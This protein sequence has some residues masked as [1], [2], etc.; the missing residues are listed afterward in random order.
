M[1]II[2]FHLHD[3]EKSDII[4]GF[5]TEVDVYGVVNITHGEIEEERIKEVLSNVDVTDTPLYMS[6]KITRYRNNIETYFNVNN[7]LEK[8]TFEIVSDNKIYSQFVHIRVMTQLPF[9]SGISAE[10]L[11][12]S[13]TTLRKQLVNGQVVFNFP[14]TNIYL[15]GNDY[16]NGL[17][18]LSGD[19]TVG[20][21]CKESTDISE[22]CSLNYKKRRGENMEMV[23][24][25]FSL[26]IIIYL[27]LYFR[28][29]YG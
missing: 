19:P 16:E 18:G 25:Y 11:K 8:T 27:L 2:G 21:I 26:F 5:P 3:E 4:H 17:I 15:M 1:L 29:Y 13:F 12:D 7:R 24:S 28:M 14:K 20:E 10:C 23:H 9:I 22:G 6:C